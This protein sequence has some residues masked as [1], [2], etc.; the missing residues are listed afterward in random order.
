M[1][2]E[3]TYVEMLL[4]IPV[5]ALVLAL[6]MWTFGIGFAADR[7]PEPRAPIEAALRLAAAFQDVAESA[8]EAA[9]GVL[10]GSRP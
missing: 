4:F 9:P 6:A 5:L 10:L 2:A 8:V 3:R 1:R 7:G